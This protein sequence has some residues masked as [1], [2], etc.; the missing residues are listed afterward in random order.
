MNAYCYLYSIFFMI[1]NSYISRMKIWENKLASNLG[2]GDVRFLQVDALHLHR[3][4]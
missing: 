4:L 1:K 3:L 2:G